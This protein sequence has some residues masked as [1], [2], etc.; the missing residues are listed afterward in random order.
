MTTGS[1]REAKNDSAYSDK[2]RGR[3]VSNGRSSAWAMCVS[4]ASTVGAVLASV[5]KEMMGSSSIGSLCLE[6][7]SFLLAYVRS[8][9]ALMSPCDHLL[10]K[11]INR[12]RTKSTQEIHVFD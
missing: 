9:K 6:M 10:V 5:W 4:V 1:F 3:G 12:N 8:S 2:K 7:K 11:N